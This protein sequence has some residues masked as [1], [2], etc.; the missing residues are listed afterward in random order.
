MWDQVRAARQ[1]APPWWPRSEWAHG[2]RA[3]LSS[4]HIPQKLDDT[5]KAD[6][7]KASQVLTPED[8]K[9]II[10]MAF[11]RTNNVDGCEFIAKYPVDNWNDQGQPYFSARSCCRLAMEIA[12]RDLA[13]LYKVSE[14]AEKEISISPEDKICSQAASSSAPSGAAAGARAS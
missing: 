3:V 2:E 14:V 7:C 9:N 4:G 11:P 10:P 12:Y 13:S 1:G 6:F 8:L 5:I